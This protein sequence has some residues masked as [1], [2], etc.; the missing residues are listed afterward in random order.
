MNVAVG[1]TI[2]LTVA[3]P[4][5]N[6]FPLN[7]ARLEVQDARGRPMFGLAASS[8]TPTS[9]TFSQSVNDGMFTF[10]KNCEN[11]SWRTDFTYTVWVT[12][13]EFALEPPFKV[14]EEGAVTFSGALPC[15]E[16]SGEPPPEDPPPP[17]PPE[18]DDPFGEP[19]I[20]DPPVGPPT[21][22]PVPCLPPSFVSPTPAVATP[23][24]GGT[25]GTGVVFTS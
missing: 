20:G 7:T 3:V 12:E 16:C 11:C 19:D 14:L 22:P 8:F 13:G 24:S 2:S 10:A 1:G 6:F 17:P 18:G 25:G 23:C 9:V 5:P 21:A 15:A 4:Q